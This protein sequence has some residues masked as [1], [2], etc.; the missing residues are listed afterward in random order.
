MYARAKLPAAFVLVCMGATT[1]AAQVDRASL[2]GA[3]KD[4]SG[5]VVA[6][7]KV[8][9][10]SVD[11]GK[12]RESRSNGDG[13][14]TIALLPV[15]T[16]SFVFSR[17]GFQTVRYE[18]ETLRV[19]E[20]LTLD[21]VLQV[22]QVTTV[23]DVEDPVPLLERNTGELG[24]V[25][26]RAEIL[27]LPVNGRN[28]A[29]LLLLAP[30]AIDDGGGNQRNIRFAG[31][32][33]D[34]NNYRFDGVDA[35][36]I[37]EQAQKSTTRLQLPEDAVEEYRVNS[38]LYTAE[39]G[40]GAGGQVD[41]VTKSGTNN[42]R[43]SAFDYVRNSALDSRSFLDLDNDPTQTGPTHV[44][45][46]RLNQ[47][48]GTLGGPIVKDKTFFFVS[49]E[50]IRQF[51]G[52]TLHAFVPSE[53]FRAQAL[54]TS[55][56]LAPIFQV[57]PAG[58]ISTCAFN[59]G[60]NCD[61][62]DEF[63]H[64]GGIRIR[65]DSSMVRLDHKFSAQTTLYLRAVRDDSFTAGPF[66]NLLDLQEINT[67]PANY[68][69]TLQHTFSPA[70]LNE[71]K[72][73]VNRAPF[74]NPQAGAFN[75]NLAV[76][77]GDFEALNN[78][79]TDN[80]VGTSLSWIDN[81]TVQHGRHTFKV[82]GEVRR[83]RLNQ[84]ITTDNSITFASEAAIINNHLDSFAY[85][86]SW[87]GRG[88]RHTFVLPYFQ[89]EW[90]MRSDLT[91]NVGLRWEYYAPITEAHGRGRIFDIQRCA[92][93]TPG[94]PGICPKGSPFFFPNYRNFD[95]RF[96]LAWAPDGLH[97]K[98][99]IRSGFGIYHGAG[100][101]DD[102]NA[103]LE[104]DNTRL[105]LSS[106]DVPNLSYP[107]DSFLPLASVQGRT[108]RA[109]QR[110]R[111][112]L[113]AEQWGVTVQQALPHDFVLQTGY[114]GS[115]GVRLF[116]RTYVN[117]CTNT[118][119][120]RAAGICTRQLSGVGQ[121]DLKRNDGNS[122][123][124]ALQASLQRHFTR[125]WLWQLQYMWSHSINDGSVGGGESNA[126]ENVAC[127]RCDRG[128][129][130]FDVRHNLVMTSV[131]E[132]PFGQGR[133]YATSGAVGKVF[134]GWSLSGIGVLHTGHPLT[135]LFNP[136]GSLL[137]DGND[138]SDQRPDLVSG[139]PLVPA[140]QG[141]DNWV[142]PAAFRSP[143]ADANG[144]LLRFGDAGRGLV[145]SPNVWQIDFAL[146]K[147]IK[148]TEKLAVEFRAEAFNIFNHDQFA[149]PN[150]SLNFNPACNDPTGIANGCAF[151]SFPTPASTLTSPGGFGVISSNVNFNSNND[152]FAPDNTGSGLPRQIE[153]GIRFTFY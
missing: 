57:Y 130:V 25:I 136:D 1:A 73:G 107:V 92:S 2:T 112:D 74:H 18:N 145:R 12:Q 102:L 119:A 87:W 30:G 111:R 135:V 34:D 125:G 44:P 81:L 68:V 131:Y 27:D 123:F 122:T 85:K 42:F 17:E 66:G 54:G 91:V 129:S 10:I 69:L 29:G 146:S 33:R 20:V 147:H 132:L 50:G 48:G 4:A 58:Q 67:K 72:F 137:R 7:A 82:G 75:Q 76:N 149:D 13:I 70:A 134:G 56:A 109:L 120:E 77:F 53:S 31:R 86:G 101:N 151:S 98:T 128:P 100:Q 140:N 51:R 49:Y 40:A 114:L 8:E 38:M 108:P 97:G 65:E 93:S 126:P 6:G 5:A 36:G 32:A 104:S 9:A 22:G 83:V 41:L 45:P 138:H 59:S 105:S 115:A 14:Y 64:L 99:V 116:A 11:T 39:Y 95:P 21:A 152:S 23:L 124:S 113:Y 148:I 90:K 3:V 80:E 62:I 110:D 28:W 133:H 71:A 142:N 117:V 79:D 78:D 47:F 43:G 61:Q 118:L 127:R 89:D 143:P 144:N 19:G 121:V 141:P 153:V 55:P 94:D 15:G 150:I 88:L 16:Y 46:F 60:G 35:T 37:Q 106:S 103:G 96:S 63:T 52:Q 139:V 26:G 84:G 24:G